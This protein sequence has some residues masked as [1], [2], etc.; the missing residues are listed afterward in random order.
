MQFL[1]IRQAA[2]Q[3]PDSGFATPGL[4]TIRQLRGK[5]GIA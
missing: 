4:G 5:I 2:I 3:H 1:S